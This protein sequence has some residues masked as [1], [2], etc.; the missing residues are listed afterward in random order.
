LSFTLS[1]GTDGSFA[2]SSIFDNK[3]RDVSKTNAF[4]NQLYH[5]IS[6]L[7]TKLLLNSGE[8]QDENCAVIKGGS[9]AGADD[10]EKARWRI[11]SGEF[12]FFS[13]SGFYLQSEPAF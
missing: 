8:T 2:P 13:P 11:T 6:H 5:D 12:L 10:A 9:S 3:P 1:S 7:D 4:S